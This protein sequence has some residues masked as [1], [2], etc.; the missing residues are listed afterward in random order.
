MPRK[1]FRN[2]GKFALPTKFDSPLIVKTLKI[3]PKQYYIA[4]NS[5]IED[6]NINFSLSF[7]DNLKNV[8]DN[9]RSGTRISPIW[10]VTSPKLNQQ[11]VETTNKPGAI[12]FLGAVAPS[13][14]FLQLP[15][16]IVANISPKDIWLTLGVH[17]LVL[18]THQENTLEKVSEF[19]KE[20]N[21]SSEIW[22]F[23][24]YDT[25]NEYKINKIEY[26]HSERQPTPRDFSFFATLVPTQKK[27]P[28]EDTITSSILE[29]FAL[30]SVIEKRSLSNFTSF[31]KDIEDIEGFIKTFFPNG[32][33]N[34]AADE[35]IDELKK[36]D[37]LL[38]LNAGL[39]RL[40]SQALSGT[41]PIFQT[42]CHFWPHSFLGTGVANYA[43]RELANFITK[44]IKESNFNEK[45]DS[46]L[47]APFNYSDA[48]ITT[49]VSAKPDHLNLTGEYVSNLE[50]IDSNATEPSP[51][52]PTR[53]S[54]SEF[55][56]I[57]TPI[58][59]F[60]GRDGFRNG[61]LT[62]S[63]PLMCVSG[64]N[65]VQ[66]NLGTITHELSHRIVSGKLEGLFKDL[67]LDFGGICA[68]NKAID[69]Y[70]KE[71][72]STQHGL[73]KKILALLLAILF[74]E[75]LDRNEFWRKNKNPE[76]FLNDAFERFSESIEE[77][78]VHIFDYYH[79]YGSDA[80]TYVDSIWLSWAVQPSI[81]DK[82][83]PYIERTLLALATDHIRESNWKELA[84]GSFSGIL[85]A[86]PLR[87]KLAFSPEM[88]ES[89]INEKVREN[90]FHFLD[91]R[92]LVIFLFSLIFKCEELKFE[93]NRD[94]FETPRTTYGSGKKTKYRY[95]ATRR[96]FLTSDPKVP[97]PYFSNPLLF[98]R[99]FS[100][101]LTPDSSKSAWLLNI[102]AFNKIDPTPVPD[103]E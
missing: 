75:V 24:D 57:P 85:K 60:S 2:T 12:C 63:A 83:F 42:E 48:D 40:A 11:V 88:I 34:I 44:C 21:I 43:L 19:S 68:D 62:T 95:T 45:F 29:F 20:S 31:G 3:K 84:C 94:P 14:I 41:T 67:R 49:N 97:T 53:D 82:P 96:A 103:E 32:E 25:P 61:A 59:F 38:T 70:L 17:N 22:H 73:A 80:K 69:N 37:V 102:L 98:L 35:N 65:C 101:D 36:R 8:L 27:N 90:I 16:N 9:W 10:E 64:C 78:L 1:S 46:A 39:S 51:A 58:T 26:I 77:W 28:Y 76:V 86:E 54:D 4:F 74:A 66:W 81:I 50:G 55:A 56:P 100:R 52:F 30:S 91:S 47:S 93:A 5:L 18:I 89:I 15:T 23:T 71:I 92:F 79:F 99:D 13:D 6:N 72:P 7:T 87:S 33:D